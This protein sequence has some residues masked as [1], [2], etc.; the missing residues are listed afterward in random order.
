MERPLSGVGVLTLTPLSL[1]L[2]VH[3]ICTNQLKGG[4]MEE[5]RR[6]CFPPSFGP[7]VATTRGANGLY[8]RVQEDGVSSRKTGKFPNFQQF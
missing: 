5:G 3:S 7:Y 8:S 6:L 2:A 4:M 1:S